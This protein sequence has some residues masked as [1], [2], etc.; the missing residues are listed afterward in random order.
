MNFVVNFFFYNFKNNFFLENKDSQIL[1]LHVLA[2]KYSKFYL[3][4]FNRTQSRRKNID[5]SETFNSRYIY[6][7]V[8]TWQFCSSNFC[9]CSLYGEFVSFV[10]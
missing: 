7:I 9:S 10:G 1:Y 8:V 6:Y 2:R 3:K 5:T 4:N